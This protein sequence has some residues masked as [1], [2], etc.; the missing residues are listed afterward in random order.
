M[1]SGGAERA[2]DDAL[3]LALVGFGLPTIVPAVVVTAA[4][5]A[6]FFTATCRIARRGIG[7]AETS[8]R[9]QPIAIP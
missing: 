2:F 9:H 5:D 1:N 8:A 7:S 4:V 3:E 6:A